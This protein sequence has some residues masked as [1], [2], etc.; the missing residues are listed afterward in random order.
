MKKETTK[1]NR[2]S[3]TLSI[4]K[5]KTFEEHAK[6]RQIEPCEVSQEDKAENYKFG[7]AHFIFF[8]YLFCLFADTE[9]INANFNQLVHCENQVASDPS[10]YKLDVNAPKILLVPYYTRLLMDQSDPQIHFCAL[11]CIRKISSME[12]CTAPINLLFES[13]IVEI[14]PQYI[15]HYT[16]PEWQIE[17]TWLIV[18][19]S[20]TEDPENIGRLVNSNVLNMVI[21]IL[22]SS[23]NQQIISNCIWIIANISA[24]N[25]CIRDVVINNNGLDAILFIASKVFSPDFE[26]QLGELYTNVIWAFSTMCKVKPKLNTEFWVSILPYFSHVIE[27][28]EFYSYKIILDACTGIQSISFGDEN[29]IQTI[30]DSE[31]I[32]KVIALYA[33]HANNPIS[34]RIL[35]I[36]GNIYAGNSRQRQYMTRL[37]GLSLLNAYLLAPEA[38]FVSTA[39]RILAG[40]CHARTHIEEV[41]YIFDE[42]DHE[43]GETLLNRIVDIIKNHRFDSKIEALM[44]I[45]NLVIDRH[46]NICGRVIYLDDLLNILMSTCLKIENV[47]I[48]CTTL[49]ILSALFLTSFESTKE[50]SFSYIM[51][52]ANTE[53]LQSTLQDLFQSEDQDISEKAGDMLDNYFEK[54]GDDDDEGDIFSPE[55]LSMLRQM[56]SGPPV[57]FSQ[58]PF[59]QTAPPK[60]NFLF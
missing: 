27:N 46:S 50:E 40:M 4:R 2:K 42:K 38:V 47:D 11:N 44:I 17:M 8:A 7:M 29:T 59:S 32:P 35:Q 56:S 60:Y 24:T 41:A 58:S 37:H 28:Y 45:N 19:L 30:V 36:I 43:R 12:E 10:I 34:Y 52:V 33:K 55:N 16:E 22:V 26:C 13:G 48:Q 21:N 18:N 25:G 57:G 20:T 51:E 15:G 14:L 31:I 1:D 39:C 23:G 49:D 9:Y 54:H 3:E 6:R 53:D 5:K